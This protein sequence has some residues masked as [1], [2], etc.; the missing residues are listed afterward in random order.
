MRAAEPGSA[1]ILS[2]FERRTG[3][4]PPISVFPNFDLDLF[5]IFRNNAGCDDPTF[6]VRTQSSPCNILS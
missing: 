2:G 3:S 5:L 4:N 6:R 1:L